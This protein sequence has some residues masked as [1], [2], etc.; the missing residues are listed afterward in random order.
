MI[1]SLWVTLLHSFARQA[2]QSCCIPW[3]TASG[4]HSFICL[5][6]ILI[7]HVA[8]HDWQQVSDTASFV[9][10][11]FSSIMLHSMIYS[12]WVTLL[13]LFARHSHQSYCIPWLTASV[14]LG[15]ICFHAFSSIMLHPMTNS[16]W[17]TLL[18]VFARH[19]YQSCCITWPTAYESHCFICLPGSLIDYI[20]SHDQQKVSDTSSFLCQAG[21]WIM[22]HPMTTSMWV[23]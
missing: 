19:S 21:S 22:L 7:N 8:S 13:H 18:H 14:W 6:D 9:C 10:Q 2:H 23:T 15:F 4:W 20:W 1:N 3:P 5:P 17:V 16:K 12:K 11:A